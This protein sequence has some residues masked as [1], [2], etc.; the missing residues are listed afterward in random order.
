MSHQNLETEEDK[1]MSEENQNLE[2]K[3]EVKMEDKIS[4]RILYEVYIVDDMLDH[5]YVIG[6]CG[7]KPKGSKYYSSCPPMQQRAKDHPWA[8]KRTVIFVTYDIKEAKAIEK[9]LID[10]YMSDPK[11][12]NEKRGGGGLREVKPLERY[13]KK[14]AM[15]GNQNAKGGKARTGLGVDYVVTDPLGN[16]YYITSPTTWAKKNF[17]D[18]W[19]YVRNAIGDVATGFKKSFRG[20]WTAVKVEKIVGEKING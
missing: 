15:M 6:A 8:I 19:E 16:Q 1:T 7:E 18:N 4:E 10:I 14:I 11:C 17:P 3:E 20:G 5:A 2:T 13:R 12:L 9:Y